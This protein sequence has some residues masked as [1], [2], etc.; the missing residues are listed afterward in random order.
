MLKGIGEFCL[1]SGFYMG[2]CEG[3]IQYILVW[4]SYICACGSRLFSG[5]WALRGMAMRSDRLNE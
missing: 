5:R 4:L 2:G 3:T 1:T